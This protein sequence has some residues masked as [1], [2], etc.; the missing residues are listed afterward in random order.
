MALP[1]H[2]ARDVRHELR[3]E[4]EDVLQRE[5]QEL[6]GRQ[7]RP[8]LAR[9][10]ESLREAEKEPP[11][12]GSARRRRRR[13]EDGRRTERPSRHAKITGLRYGSERLSLIHISEPTRP[14]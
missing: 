9:E 13:G 8:C 11:R 6:P 3:R 12:P 7:V 1:S 14:Y 2:L 4:L 5:E 10:D